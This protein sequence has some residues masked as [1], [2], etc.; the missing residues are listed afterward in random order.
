MRS[1]FFT[2]GDIDGDGA[3]TVA[4]AIGVLRAL[5][6]GGELSCLDSGDVD[7]NGRVNIT[8]A[9]A[10]LLHLFGGGPGPADP[11]ISGGCGVDPTRDFLVCAAHPK[12][13]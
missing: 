4:D 5:F 13:R 8:D 12:C 1:G 3:P 6:Q 10:I 7:V 2:R 9:V 11:G